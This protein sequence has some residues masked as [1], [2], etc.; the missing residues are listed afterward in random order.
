MLELYGLD[1]NHTPL[2]GLDRLIQSI[3]VNNCLV[4]GLREVGLSGKCKR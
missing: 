3:S 1:G 4:S 2:F